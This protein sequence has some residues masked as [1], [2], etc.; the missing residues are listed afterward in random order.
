MSFFR[1]IKAELVRSFIIMRRYWFATLTGLIVGYGMLMLLIVGFMARREEVEGLIDTRL[2]LNPEDATNAAL[3]F[4]IG[5]FAFGIVGTFSQGLQG[6]MRSGQL[7]Q[8][9]LS[10]YGL[11]TNFMA[12]S[13]VG[14]VTSVLSSSVMLY[15]VAKTVDGRLYADPVPTIILLVLTYFNL[16]GFGF[17]VGGL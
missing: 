13:M 7:E 6:M 5:L 15:F 4:I 9:C 14:A 2:G 12:R 3:G 16:I 17:M 10:P 8:L 11:V 1:V